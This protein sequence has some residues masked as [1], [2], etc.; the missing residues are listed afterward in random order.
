MTRLL[1]LK[2][3]TLGFGLISWMLNKQ[4]GM[5]DSRLILENKP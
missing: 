5:F 4:I 3:Q 2:C 1:F